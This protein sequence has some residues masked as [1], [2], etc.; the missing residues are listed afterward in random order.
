[1]QIAKCQGSGT[2]EA[3]YSVMNYI[4]FDLSSWIPQHVCPRSAQQMQDSTGSKVTG[5]MGQTTTY[6]QEQDR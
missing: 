4:F 1:M 2:A 5:S 6:G 3:L